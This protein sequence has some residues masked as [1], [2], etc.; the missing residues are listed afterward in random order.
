MEDWGITRVVKHY[1]LTP[2]PA[3]AHATQAREIFAPGIAACE[4][5]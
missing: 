3:S 1:D 2:G 4:G 5:S